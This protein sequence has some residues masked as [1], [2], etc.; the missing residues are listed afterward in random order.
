MKY[1]LTG[2]FSILYIYFSFGRVEVSR[3]PKDECD[4][5]N[6]NRVNQDYSPLSMVNWLILEFYVKP[7]YHIIEQVAYQFYGGLVIFHVTI[8]H[9]E[10][11]KIFKQIYP[12]KIIC[13]SSKEYESYISYRNSYFNHLYLWDVFQVSL[14][15]FN[16][17]FFKRYLYSHNKLVEDRL[18]YI[19]KHL[20]DI[21]CDCE[22]RFVCMDSRKPVKSKGSGK[23]YH[24]TECNYN[25]YIAKWKSEEGYRTLAECGVR[26][27]ESGFSIDHERIAEINKE[28]WGA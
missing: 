20:T 8:N 23:Y 14:H 3:A 7:S 11:N 18:Q 10:L 1:K 15:G 5:I 22:F 21:C 24:T 9:K 28:L 27:D 2:Y 4:Y 26:S 6:A 17:F 12:N 19:G 25:P 16:P 13:K